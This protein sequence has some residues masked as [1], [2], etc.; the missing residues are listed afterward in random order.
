MTQETPSYH[1]PEGLPAFE[2]HKRFTLTRDPNLDPLLFLR[3]ESDPAL[4]FICIQVRFLVS[5]YAYEL[6]EASAALLGVPPGR[7]SA[8]DENLGCMAILSVSSE[9]PST[10]NL[11][12]PVVINFENGL[13]LQAVQVGGEWSHAHPIEVLEAS[14]C[15]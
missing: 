1:F 13:G 7:Y 14:Q 8:V 6:D 2:D 10:A 9:G 4:R 15:S 11:L 5:G 3:S 12:A